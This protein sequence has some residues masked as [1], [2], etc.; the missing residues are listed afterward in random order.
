[1]L[2]EPDIRREIEGWFRRRSTPCDQVDDLCQAALALAWSGRRSHD[3]SD[4]RAWIFAN[5]ALVLRS[6]RRDEGRQRKRLD[7]LEGHDAARDESDPE[8]RVDARRILGRVLDGRDSLSSEQAALL[9]SAALGDS[10]AAC[11]DRIARDTGASRSPA[12]LRQSRRRL[13]ADL[14]DLGVGITAT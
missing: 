12:W 2:A 9:D 4:P 7:P 14:G 8:R 5:A 6:W 13:R 11:L 10:D 1:M 3:L